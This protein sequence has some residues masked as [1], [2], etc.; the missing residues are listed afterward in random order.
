MSDAEAWERA[1]AGHRDCA[2]W[3]IDG[4][5]GVLV[6]ACG[7]VLREPGKAAA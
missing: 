4:R 6:C 5:D 1:D 7:A 3:T 2:G